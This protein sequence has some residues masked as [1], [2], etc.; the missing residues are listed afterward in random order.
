MHLAAIQV[1][2]HRSAGARR[3]MPH[4]YYQILSIV[5]HK[6]RSLPNACAVCTAG[7]TR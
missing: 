5:P 3:A 1:R 4:A 2:V 6:L 7:V